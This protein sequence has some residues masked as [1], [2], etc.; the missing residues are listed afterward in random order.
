MNLEVHS[1]VAGVAEGLATVFTLMRLH[2]HMPHK[3]H[4]E[5][6]GSDECPGTHAAFEFPLP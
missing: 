1:E 4:V 5:L 2:P 6:S 3:V